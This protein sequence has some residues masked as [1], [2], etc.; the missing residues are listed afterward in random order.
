MACLL[1]TH[2][3]TRTIGPAR[4]RG[5]QEEESSEEDDATEPGFLEAFAKWFV[6]IRHRAE[7][8]QKNALQGRTE[9][10]T[11]ARTVQDRVVSFANWSPRI[12]HGT[13][14]AWAQCGGDKNPTGLPATLEDRIP[15]ISQMLQ[16]HPSA[17][18]SSDP[19]W[20][21]KFHQ[22]PTHTSDIV[23]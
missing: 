1:E 4:R 8:S 17:L 6:G 13:K 10:I 22:Y 3:G 11:F 18:L 15:E 23:V 2:G 7:A 21:L 12:V 19:L 20:A 14:E 5:G 16:K 9:N